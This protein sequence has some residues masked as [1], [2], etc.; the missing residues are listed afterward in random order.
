MLTHMHKVIHLML[1]HLIKGG[2]VGEV[3]EASRGDRTLTRQWPDSEACIRSVAHRVGCTQARD[4]TLLQ[5]LDQTHRGC[6]RSLV[7]YIDV[8]RGEG[9]RGPDSGLR[10]IA[11]E[12]TCPVTD[13]SLR[14]LTG[15]DRTPWVRE[16]GLRRCVQPW[17]DYCAGALERTRGQRVRSSR[18]C[19]RSPLKWGA[20]VAD[21]WRSAAEVEQSGHVARIHW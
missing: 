16:S 8:M 10:P 1:A 11:C 3:E 2:E 13:F 21:H 19:V 7:T 20:G 5:V 18:L 15:V 17:R 14:M 4:R 6:I 12:R 9:Q